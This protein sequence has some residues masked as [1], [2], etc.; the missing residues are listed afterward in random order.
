MTREDLEAFHIKHPDLIDQLNQDR[1]EV[2]PDPPNQLFHYT[3][4]DGLLGIVQTN[5]LWATNIRFLNDSSELKYGVELFEEVLGERKNPIQDRLCAEYKLLERVSAHSTTLEVFSNFVVCLSENG[6]QLSQWRAYGGDGAG[7]SIGFNACSIG[8]LEWA[9][10]RSLFL[11]KV[12]YERGRQ[13]ELLGNLVDRFVSRIKDE[14]TAELQLFSSLLLARVQY[15]LVSFK[16][17]A[18]QE[19][20]EWR[21]VYTIPIPTDQRDLRF[22]A[23]GGLIV[24]Y[25]VLTPPGHD[26]LPIESVYQGPRAAPEIGEE[27][28]KYLLWKS[29]YKNVEVKDSGIPLRVRNS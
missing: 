11:F 26:L 20:G 4:V 14:G 7:Y 9:D 27:S 1:A 22:R 5:S 23:S 17:N 13:K 6:N 24:P 21:L 8:Q 29:G 10:S 19:E 12:C 3:N 25:Y 18:F 2:L 28:L 15:Y 16:N